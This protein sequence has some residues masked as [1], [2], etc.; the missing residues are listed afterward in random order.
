MGTMAEL[1]LASVA[2]T[3]W[4]QCLAESQEQGPSRCYS[5][6]VNFFVGLSLGFLPFLTTSSVFLLIT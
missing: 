2:L 1:G 4:I 5:C 6:L 3:A